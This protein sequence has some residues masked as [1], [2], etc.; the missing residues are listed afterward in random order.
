MPARA[1]V[2]VSR[3]R[4]KIHSGLASSATARTA[5]SILARLPQC[6]GQTPWT[7]LTEARHAARHKT[8]QTQQTAR[9]TRHATWRIRAAPSE[10]LEI[11]KI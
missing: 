2:P 10:R 8:H 4:I 7:T 1:S 6:L 11:L 3:R 5:W 9:G